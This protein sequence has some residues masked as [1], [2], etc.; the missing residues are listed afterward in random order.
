MID[1]DRLVSNTKQLK[2]L[3]SL[4][5]HEF[6][7]LL[8]VFSTR[9]YQHYKHYTIVGKR[10]KLP[11][12]NYRKDTGTL[13]RVEHKLL[14]ILI[15]FKTGSI[16][17]QLAAEFDL[18]QTHVS[19]WL[20]ALRPILEQAIVDLHL[21]PAQNMDEL[22]RLFRQRNDPTKDSPKPQTLNMDVTERPIGRNID[23][24]AQADDYSGKQGGHRLKNTVMCDEYQFIH[25]VGP[26]WNGSMHDKAMADEELPH[27]EQLSRYDLWLSKDKGYQGY[28]PAGVNL[29]EPYRASRGHPLTQTQK[30]YNSWV[31]PVRIVVEHCISGIK[32]MKLLAHN[33]R[34]AKQSV[35]H[36]I[37]II[38]C[39]L[40]NLR[41]HFRNQAYAC[42]AQRVHAHLNF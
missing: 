4:L 7:A 1:I 30:E 27:L 41:V 16:Q 14:F 26:T 13:P 5:P 8:N 25:F 31:S 39:G 6:E 33:I 11:L 9:W 23:D 3:T 17:Q 37:F 24:A 34:Y 19:H 28:R 38:G 12:I 15:W 40:H 35:R 32:R 10:R 21:Q 18:V 20:K 42:G 2:A 29:L 22:L 36:Q